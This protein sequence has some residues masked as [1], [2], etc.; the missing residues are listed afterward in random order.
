VRGSVAPRCLEFELH[1][2]GGVELHPLVRQRRPGDVGALTASS[3]T[4][5]GE[6]PVGVI[7]GD[8]ASA[9][10]VARPGCRQFIVERGGRGRGDVVRLA[11]V[12]AQESVQVLCLCAS[13]YQSLAYHLHLSHSDSHL[14][15][16]HRSLR[17]PLRA[18]SEA[19]ARVKALGPPVLA[20]GNRTRCR[21]ASVVRVKY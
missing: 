15:R 10:V 11:P 6:M 12:P 1:L 9:P 5:S 20:D 14:I 4:E 8:L 19:T 16:S 7:D 13:A 3:I 17:V 18:A 2:P 21:C